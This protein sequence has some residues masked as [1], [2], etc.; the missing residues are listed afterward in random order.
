[1]SNR[2][3]RLGAV[4]FST[5]V[6]ISLAN[7]LN[8]FSSMLRSG[9]KYS[10]STSKSKSKDPQREEGDLIVHGSAAFDLG[11]WKLKSSSEETEKGSDVELESSG[12][13][14]SPKKCELFVVNNG[15]EKLLFCWVDATGRLRHYR[16]I[17]DGSIKDKSVPNHHM[18]H[19]QTGDHFVCIRNIDPLPM[20]MREIR[21]DSFVFSYTPLKGDIQHIIKINLPK[22]RSLPFFFGAGGRCRELSVTLEIDD[23]DSTSEVIDSTSK[24]YNVCNISGFKVHYE[25]GSL[26][27]PDFMPTIQADMD[28]MVSMLPPG[29]CAKLRYDTP[30]WINTSMTYG[31]K[32]KPVVAT[33]CCYH[34]RG[35]GSWLQRNGLHAEKEGCVE[36]FCAEAY[37]KSRNHWGTG[38]VLV[39]EFSHVF[40]NKH[41]PN[42]FECEE[43]HQAYTRAMNAKLYDSVKVHGPQGKNGKAKAYACT[44][45][46]EFFA[47][48]SVAYLYSAD[49]QTEYNKWFPFNRAQLQKHDPDTYA[50]LENCWNRYETDFAAGTLKLDDDDGNDN[51]EKDE[52]NEAAKEEKEEEEEEEEASKILRQETFDLFDSSDAETRQLLEEVK[53]MEEDEEQPTAAVAGK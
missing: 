32:K 15:N 34:P 33:T 3:I 16:P 44:N 11:T 52:G 6:L 29:A 51:R 4:L 20:N 38:G 39:H 30:I 22:K 26:D 31:T 53:Q 41:C 7:I 13:R 28:Q 42:A 14:A 19:S 43:V 36:I 49:S 23:M 12:N 1:M 48:L 17:N 18:E 40:H 25:P 9:G 35:G 21:E 8:P 24:H 45:C 27:V 50:V 37:L 2:Q 46:M 47:E 5:I 10:R